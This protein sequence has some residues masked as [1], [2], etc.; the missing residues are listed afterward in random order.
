MLGLSITGI[1]E[2]AK[3]KGS[4]QQLKITFSSLFLLNAIATLVVLL[5]LILSIFIVPTLYEHRD[6]MFIG[7]AKLIFNLF[8]TEWFFKG[9]EDF[10][11]ITI[12]SVV[13]KFL[14]V[15]SIFVFVREKDD[16]N[17]YYALLVAM[18]VVNAI[19]NSVYRKRFVS[20][21][22]KNITFTPFLR[23]FLTIGI[24]LILTST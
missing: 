1:R 4:P 7:I 20:F 24:Y 21:S 15:V 17:I 11:Y 3:H 13:V 9:M 16:F 2:I 23:S 19:F 14:F 10:K 5:L 12:R 22:F 8:L 18:V 6:M